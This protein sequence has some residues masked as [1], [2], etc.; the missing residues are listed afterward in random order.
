MHPF[1]LKCMCLNSFSR[2]QDF[3]CFCTLSCL[4]VSGC[5]SVGRISSIRSCGCH[6]NPNWQVGHPIPITSA[7]QNSIFERVTTYDNLQLLFNIRTELNR[8]LND[9]M[10]N[11]GVEV[12]VAD[13]A[14]GW[15]LTRTPR[16]W[17]PCTRMETSSCPF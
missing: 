12:L 7:H 15:F 3:T 17:S 11:P 5:C 1:Q 6:R 13:P 8:Y 4:Y 10:E 2:A 9:Q 14:G 16:I